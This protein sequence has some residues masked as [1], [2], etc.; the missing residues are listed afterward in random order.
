[1]PDLRVQ[2]A[3]QVFSTIPRIKWCGEK[4]ECSLCLEEFAKGEE[5]LKLKCSHVFHEQCLGPW[6]LKSRECPLCK[7]HF[8]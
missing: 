5:L 2:I 1:M 7:Q 8:A 4:E 3:P 6:V